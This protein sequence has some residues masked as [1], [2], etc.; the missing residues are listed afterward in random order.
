MFGVCGWA[1][2]LTVAICPDEHVSFGDVKREF[3]F[4]SVTKSFKPEQGK[5]KEER[6]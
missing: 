3:V 1:F 6:G 4:Y 2:C 5:R